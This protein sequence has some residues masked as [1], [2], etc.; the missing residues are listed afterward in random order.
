MSCILDYD[1]CIYKGLKFVQALQLFTD[2]IERSLVG[3]KVVAVIKESTETT[4]EL[5][6]LTE[7]E[8]IV[9]VDDAT[10]DLYLEIPADE[11]DVDADY[12]IYLVYLED[13]ALPTTELEPILEG[14]VVFKKGVL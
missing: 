7:G 1:L 9:I 10:G 3:K 13:E 5:F 14:R 4:T 2:G 12:G 8:G 11:T 6:R